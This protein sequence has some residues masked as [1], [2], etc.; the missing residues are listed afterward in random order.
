MHRSLNPAGD[1][2][3]LIRVTQ[4][5]GASPPGDEFVG[6]HRALIKLSS[7]PGAVE[8]DRSS[9]TARF[10]LTTSL[11]DD[12]LVHPYLAPVAAV[13]AWWLQRE[14]FHAG[15][16]VHASGTWALLGDRESGK[17]TTLGY[18]ATRQHFVICDDVLV[19]SKG[20]ALA[21]PRS[22]DLRPDAAGRIGAGREL[23]GV[24]RRRWRIDLEPVEPESRLAGWVY[25]GWGDRAEIKAV[26]GRQRLERLA[27][28]RSVRLPSSDP[29][30]FLRLAALPAWEYRR[31]PGEPVEV[32][33]ARLLEWLEDG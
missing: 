12:E 21:G 11:S 31:P 19:L 22:V 29:G 10:H 16:F 15:A 18:L 6:Q 24:G 7:Q 30:G 27:P 26:P 32:S 13:W 25:L 23:D 17:S 5:I 4:H 1:D 14:A 8:L 3:P 20:Q 28:H 33:V 2:W 9:S